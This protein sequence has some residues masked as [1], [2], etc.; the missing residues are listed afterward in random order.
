MYARAAATVAIVLTVPDVRPIQF[1]LTGDH[2]PKSPP[3]PMCRASNSVAVSA[4][5]GHEAHGSESADGRPG[6]PFAG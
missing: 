2:V 4:L 3:P 1:A 5:M 6:W